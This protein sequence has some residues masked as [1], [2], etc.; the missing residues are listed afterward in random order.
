[1]S[2]QESLSFIRHCRESVAD[3]PEKNRYLSARTLNELVALAVKEGYQVTRKSL[4]TAHAIDWQMRLRRFSGS[5]ME[6]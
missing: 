4:R 6:E 5:S 1:M 2:I 3:E